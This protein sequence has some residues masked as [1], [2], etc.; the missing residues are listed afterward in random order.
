MKCKNI[1]EVFVHV[2]RLRLSEMQ[3]K[4]LIFWGA[5]ATAV[6]GIRVTAGQGTFIRRLADDSK[7]SLKERIDDA[8]GVHV[9][10]KWR[11]AL[12]DLVTI[13]GDLTGNYAYVDQI[14]DEQIQAMRRICAGYWARA[15]R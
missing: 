4:N 1:G 5:G 14:D 7:L 8:L 6:L 9:P 13:L 3:P 10:A 2:T 15:E 12:S 11:S